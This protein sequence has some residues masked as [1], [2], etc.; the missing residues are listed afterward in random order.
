MILGEP[1]SK[2]N[3]RRLIPAGRRGPARI[4]KS[5]KALDYVASARLQ[6]ARQRCWPFLTGDL[7]FTATLYY[8]SRRPDLDASVLLDVLQGCVYEND[9]AVKEIHLYHAIDK[10]RPRAHVVVEVIG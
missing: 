8:A 2:A 1:A 4:I 7:R 5:A 6:L 3:S 10:K 9:R